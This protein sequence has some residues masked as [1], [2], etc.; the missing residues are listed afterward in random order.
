MPHDRHAL[1]AREAE[2]LRHIA[3]GRSNR[4]IGTALDI[5]EGTVKGHLQRIY[6]KMH[7]TNRTQ[8]AVL[9]RKLEARP[10]LPADVD[11]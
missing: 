7:V 9:H 2:I 10:H 1:T 5:T 4:E 11:R 3:A 8:A 6:R